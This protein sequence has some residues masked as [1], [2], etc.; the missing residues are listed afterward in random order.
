VKVQDEDPRQDPMLI[1]QAYCTP[2]GMVI[3]KY[4]QL[5]KQVA[6]EK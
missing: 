6:G 4:G 5:V 2:L 1:D 3:H